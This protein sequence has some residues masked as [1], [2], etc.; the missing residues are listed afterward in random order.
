MASSKKLYL[1]VNGLQNVFYE[2]TVWSFFSSF[3]FVVFIMFK[4]EDSDV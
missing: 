2:S 4:K 3:P 1:V